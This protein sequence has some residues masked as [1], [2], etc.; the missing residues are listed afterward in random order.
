MM[1]RGGGTDR[2]NGNRK[3]PVRAILETYGKRKSGGEFP[4]KLRLGGPR[5]NG[6]EGDQVGQKLWRDGIQHLTGYRNAAAGQITEQLSRQAQAFV[7]LERL[8]YIRVVNQPLPPNGRPRFLEIGTHDYAQ[9]IGESGGNLLQPTG[10]FKSGSGIMDRA[11][12]TNDQ[13]TVRGAGNDRDG[14]FTASKDGPKSIFGGWNFGLKKLWGDQG[15]ITQHSHIVAHLFY[16]SRWHGEYVQLV[17]GE[18][19][20]CPFENSSLP[21][22]DSL[23]YIKLE[24]LGATGKGP[25]M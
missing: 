10:I 21:V 22:T 1:A 9:I 18:L 4:M 8:V 6:T 2:V 5:A 7:D 20:L 12:T 17:L 24:R 23:A 25:P 13:K 19:I 3:A 14:I 16:D 11:W 15:V